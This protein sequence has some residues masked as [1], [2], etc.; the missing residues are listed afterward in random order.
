MIEFCIRGRSH[1]APVLPVS[2]CVFVC[3]SVVCALHSFIWCYAYLRGAAVYNSRISVV[4]RWF[5]CAVSC[6][7][8]MHPALADWRARRKGKERIEDVMHDFHE[9]HM[10][11]FHEAHRT[12]R[13]EECPQ[14]R[15]REDHNL[16]KRSTSQ[17]QYLRES[18]SDYLC[19]MRKTTALVGRLHTAET[20]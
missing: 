10:H 16:K 9:A 2:A 1:G 20:R 19:A 15:G 7:S 17:P 8:A 4:R 3:I 12:R 6:S 18:S 14:C 13:Q 5:T 11:D